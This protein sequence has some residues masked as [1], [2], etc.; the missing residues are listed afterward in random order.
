MSKSDR[1][2]WCVDAV[3]GHMRSG[4]SSFAYERLLRWGGGVFVTFRGVPPHFRP[5][6]WTITDDD[7][8]LQNVDYYL[9]TYRTLQIKATHGRL[10]RIIAALRGR[11]R[12]NVVFDDS[13]V[14][15]N[16][17]QRT[18]ADAVNALDT[19]LQEC[20]Q[21]YV[22]AQLTTHRAKKQLSTFIQDNAN[23]YWVGP[24]RK[25]STVRDL[26][27]LS[28][29]PLGDEELGKML[30]DNPARKAILLKGE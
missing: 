22:C 12:I 19:Y 14:L 1:P 13:W 9:R 8:D 28:E 17:D 21:R 2:A 7:D 23:I 18:K 29:L 26:C 15:L 25:P 11:D 5:R 27:E 10:T 20:G 16:Q 3:L 6:P 4:K 24:A 30:W